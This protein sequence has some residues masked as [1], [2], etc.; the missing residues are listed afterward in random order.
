MLYVLYGTDTQK[1][2]LKLQNLLSSLKKKKPNAEFFRLE[3]EDF[4]PVQLEEFVYSQGL[5]EK[6]YVVV[7]DKILENVEAKAYMLENTKNV[8]ES[9]NV[10][11]LIEEKIDASTLKKLEKVSEKVEE[12]NAREQRPYNMF[13]LTDAL[14]ERN[15]KKLW[16]LYTEALRD[17]KECEE[18]H[19]LFVWQ[20]KSMILASTSANANDA[21]MKP[22]PYN[23]AK[24]YASN[25]TREELRAL[26]QKLLDLLYESR[27]TKDL[28]VELERF[29]L[30]I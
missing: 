1:T 8:G 20:V 18:I 16:L 10:F 23:K 7:L 3:G 22:F 19:G 11:I 28:G 15:K 4:S 5:F 29:V 25:F 6:K 12:H 27:R 26:S 13:A 2:R 21:G 17:G 30:N 24:G 9:E 14:G